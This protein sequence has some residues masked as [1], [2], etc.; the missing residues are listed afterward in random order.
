MNRTKH[1]NEWDK[2]YNRNM[3]NTVTKA[4]V[5][6]SGIVG[7]TVAYS[8]VM[9][10]VVAE[11]ALIPGHNR[12]KAWGEALDLQHSMEFQERNVR[13]FSDDYSTCRDADVV[14]ITASPAFDGTFDR[15]HMMLRTGE[16]VKEVVPR[17][18]ESGF[19]GIFIVVSNPVDVMAYLVYRLSGLPK[20]RVIGTGTVLETARLKCAIGQCMRIDPRSIDCYVMGEHG[21][22]MMV[23]WSHVRAGGKN[24]L[25]IMQENPDGLRG[26]TLDQ[27]VE[28]TREAGNTVMKAKGN[29][30]YAIASAVTRI[31]KVILHDD[32]RIIPVSALLE[33]EYGERDVFCG[34]PAIINRKGIKDIGEFHLLPDELALFHS[35]AER[36]RAA[37]ARL[38]L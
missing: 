11:I 31:V 12:K 15:M 22:S 5:V 33:G 25:D 28:E 34:V 13:V 14:I 4:V 27:L 19:D 30:Q 29:T 6:G 37:I 7:T 35:S 21:D 10:G 20:Q 23:P 26:V 18:M 32:N 38:G 3:K 2:K 8:L 16:I 36:I 17:V 24:F 1:G 9:Q